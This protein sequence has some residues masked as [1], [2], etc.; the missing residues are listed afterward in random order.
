MFLGFWILYGATCARSVQAGDAGEFM[1]IAAAGGVAHPPGYP[2]FSLLAQWF[3]AL[4]PGEN[5][6]FET[7]L[8]NAGLAAATL[9]ILHGAIARLTGS[10]L[11]GLVTAGALGFSQHFWGRAASVDALVL[12]TL[13]AALILAVAVAIA[14]GRRGPVWA[15]VLGLAVATGVANHHTVVWLTPLCVYGLWRCLPRPL[16]TRSAWPRVAVCG[17][18]VVP[19]FV[20]YLLLLRPGGA[21]RWGDTSSLG[22]LV[23]HFLRRDYGT[24]DVASGGQAVAGYANPL[25]LVQDLGADLHLLGLLG[26][27]GVYV[28]LR[29]TRHDEEESVDRRGVAAALGL[30][31]LLAG[32]VFLALVSSRPEGLGRLVVAR[33]FLLPLT[34]FACFVGIG[35]GDLLQRARGRL[36]WLAPACLGVVLGASLVLHG[37]RSTLRDWHVLEDHVHNTARV[38]GERAL[39]IGYGDAMLLGY[40][41]AQEVQGLRPD[42]TYVEPDL[43]GLASYRAHLARRDPGLQLPQP[44]QATSGWIE[45]LVRRNPGRPVY[46]A[47][48]HYNDK[49]LMR[50]LRPA[51]AHGTL[52]RLLPPGERRPTPAQVEAGLKNM[53]AGFTLRSRI[54]TERQALRTFEAEVFNQYAFAWLHLAKRYGLTGDTAGRRRCLVQARELNPWL[55]PA[56]GGS[57]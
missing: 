28:G 16:S 45:Q 53:L 13:T 10:S 40:L 57:P 46:M 26:L 24:F 36:S 8:F 34:L 6:A 21:W 39:V 1:T 31:L 17:L 44:H 43:R 37:P 51:D 32:P 42:L 49:A 48:R 2:L 12:G 41:Y 14:R 30:S 38:V 7:A 52:L 50:S 19:G 56:V 47:F 54:E 15:Y 33:F 9:G 11:A 55:V 22:G 3:V 5:A 4:F 29:P 18:G 20:A 25:A 23:H 27:W 35:A